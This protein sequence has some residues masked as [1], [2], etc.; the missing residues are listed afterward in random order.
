MSLKP[1]FFNL[2]GSSSNFQPV[3]TASVIE[4]PGEMPAA[5]AALSPTS[6][7]FH[8]PMAIGSLTE[9]C[10]RGP[11]AFARGLRLCGG[12]CLSA[13]DSTSSIT[14][15]N[16]NEATV[17]VD[18]TPIQ[19]LDVIAVDLQYRFQDSVLSNRVQSPMFEKLIKVHLG[20]AGQLLRPEDINM[21][22]RS[23]AEVFRIFAQ[24]QR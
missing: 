10:Q 5:T 12:G 21:G 11:Q 19:M 2:T 17:T 22:H 23:I 8:L 16:P 15:S 14:A 7:Q 4:P 9:G 3:E 20:E 24:Q 18:L 6:N 13:A 1:C